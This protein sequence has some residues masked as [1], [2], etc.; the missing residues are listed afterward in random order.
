MKRPEILA[1]V[2]DAERLDAALLYGAD[3][4]Y[5]AGQQFGMRAAPS[6]FTEEELA[7]AVQKA[8]AAGVR[9]H[10]TVNVLPRGRDMEMLPSYLA[11]LQ[12]IGVDALILADLG[13]MALARQYAP[14]VEQHVS[15]QMGVVNYETARVLYEM[16][17]KR[18][19][20][21]RELSMEEVAEICAKAPSGLEVECFV[22][23][24][25]CMGFSGRCMLSTYLTGRDSNHGEC[26]QSCRWKY[27]I[28][29]EKRPDAI[30]G[31]E[32]DET[33]TYFFNA[34]DL[35][36][37]DHVAELATVGVRS[38]KI[39]GRAKA[40]YYVAVTTNAYRQA[41]DGFMASGCAPD[42]R[43]EPWLSEELYTISHRPYST[44]FYYGHPDQHTA[45]NSYIRNWQVVAIVKGYENGELLLEQRNRFCVGDTLT[46]LPPLEKPYDIMVAS[47]TDGEGESID[48]A[49]HPQMAVRLPFD[50]ELPIG[51]MFRRKV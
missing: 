29:E 33:G 30:Y 16:G 27:R 7:A 12:E 4:V 51:T 32:Q 8:H 10:V 9:V 41:V 31:V 3:A 50:R 25:M 18:V 21:A 17:A 39:E 23:G 20:L 13:A 40:P 15:T 19:V 44:G 35:N 49:P 5:L 24:A 14:N 28:I 22:H 47:M 43:P 38:F 42:Y 34:K 6:N 11:Y 1:P 46:V 48:C 37:L 26:A 2:G 36:M 45:S